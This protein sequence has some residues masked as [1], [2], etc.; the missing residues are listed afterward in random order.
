[1]AVT[2]VLFDLGGVLTPDPWETVLFHPDLGLLRDSRVSVADAAR[3]MAAV[4]TDHAE[5][6]DAIAASFWAGAQ[7]VF[8]AQFTMADVSA[9][10]QLAITA[11]D[12]FGAT[13]AALTSAGVRIGVISNNTPFFY[14]WQSDLL[15]LPDVVDNSLSFLSHE[16]GISKGSGLFELAAERISAGET[17]VVEDRLGNIDR[18]ERCGFRTLHFELASGESLQQAVSKAILI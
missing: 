15:A 8:H 12:E 14:E 11:N 17:V 6:P 4:W 16:Q 13:T 9:V 10:A 5:R 18:A 2:T 7:Q 1:M 3:S